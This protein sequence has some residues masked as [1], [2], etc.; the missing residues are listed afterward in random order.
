MITA[1]TPTEEDRFAAFRHSSFRRYFTARF[2]TSSAT[3]IVSV[4]VGYQLYDETGS[5]LL[6]GIIAILSS[7]SAL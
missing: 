4:A 5:K 1:P 6:L 2:L 7:C 3:Q